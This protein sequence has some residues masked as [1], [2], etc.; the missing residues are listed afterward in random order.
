MFSRD[1]ERKVFSVTSFAERRA[2]IAREV[3]PG[4]AVDLGCGPTGLLLKD[5]A[6]IPGVKAVGADFCPEMIQQSRS[7]TT[8][9]DIDY[10]VADNRELPF[11][12]RTIDT[13]IAV[14]SFV[15]ETRQ[16]VD[17]MFSEAARVLRAAGKL[18]ALLPAFEMSLVARDLW[19]MRV[20][21]DEVEH[22]E[23][24]TSG[25]QCFYM[26]EDIANLISRSGF[27][28][29]QIERMVFSHA[30]EMSSVRGVYAASLAGVPEQRLWRAPLF[31]HLLIA[32]R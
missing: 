19:G 13:I 14:N 23:C 16:E 10:V 4:V 32:T 7:V 17:D 22:R 31:E 30:E 12:N 24:D 29:Y 6:G 27:R 26:I 8:G 2:R 20:Q 15:P 18:V 11:P 21:L 3:G 28:D 9:Y 1:Y 5:M 25:W